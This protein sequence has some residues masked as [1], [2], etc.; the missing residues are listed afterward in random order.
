MILRINEELHEKGVAFLQ[1]ANSTGEDKTYIH[2]FVM[3][4]TTVGI[5]RVE[6]YA[7]EE[8]FVTVDKISKR[9]RGYDLYCGRIVE[10]PTWQIDITNLLTVKPGNIRLK[11]WNELFTSN[12]YL[13]TNNLIDVV[14]F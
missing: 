14:M 4:N 11:F 5:V 1:L 9:E 7:K 13:D 10:W 3:F 8:V 2:E 12:E 6:S